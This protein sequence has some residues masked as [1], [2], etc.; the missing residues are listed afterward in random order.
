[1]IWP[2]DTIKEKMW[3]TFGE[4]CV[5]IPMALLASTVV[6]SLTTIAFDAVKTRL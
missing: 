2:Y 4:T 6:G 5:N 3:I 1:M